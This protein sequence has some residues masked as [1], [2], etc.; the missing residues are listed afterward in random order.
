MKSNT[1]AD[2]RRRFNLLGV[3]LL[4]SAMGLLGCAPVVTV[5]PEKAVAELANQ[6][7][8]LLIAGDI[9]KAYEFTV[10]SYRAVVDLKTYEKKF[11][12]GGV[13]WTD[14]KATK[15]VCSADKCDVVVDVTG[16]ALAGS[17]RLTRTVPV[18]EVWVYEKDGWWQFEKF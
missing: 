3:G 2:I 12:G 8:K 16:T 13:V 9:A 15:V 11:A 4:V 17:T 10:P 14:A 5:P 6:K 18:S 7:W 1:S